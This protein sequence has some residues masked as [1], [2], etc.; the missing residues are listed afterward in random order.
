MYELLYGKE[1]NKVLQAAN[2]VPM[3]LCYRRLKN[4]LE[5]AVAMGFVED[6][7]YERLVYRDE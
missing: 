7:E 2:G 5:K 3:K 4:E 1:L 6:K